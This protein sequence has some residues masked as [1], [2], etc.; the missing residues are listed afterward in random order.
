MRPRPR[1]GGDPVR[2]AAW[3]WLVG[4]VVYVVSE[5]LAVVAYPGFSLARDYISALGIPGDSPR[6]TT[7]NVGAFIVHGLLFAVAGVVAASGLSGTR[8]AR[9]A[10]AGLAVTNGVG[11]LL[12]G[13]FH[14]GTGPLHG[15]GALLAI[16]GGNAATILAGGLLRTWGAPAAHCAASR[17]AGVI[18]IGCFV[19]LLAVSGADTGIEGAIERG[20][21]YTIIGW[22]LVTGVVLLV[23]G[24][25]SPSR[26]SAAA[27]RGTM[28]R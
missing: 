24:R 13:A 12:V 5:V 4:G 8:R 19:A 26:V 16:V 17:A 27:R 1:T 6:A 3:L 20:S 22:D 2:V 9:A 23:S 28:E 21:V 11:N 18:G 25:R 10:F 15:V 7:M 14:S